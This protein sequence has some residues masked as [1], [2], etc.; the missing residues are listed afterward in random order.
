MFLFHSYVSYKYFFVYQ[1]RTQTLT[2][3][4]KAHNQG[5]SAFT[6]PIPIKRGRGRPRKNPLVS[7][8][9]PNISNGAS[10]VPIQPGS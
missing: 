10:T 2:I 3:I 7:Q 9:S 6:T 5:I 4:C 8:V 1:V